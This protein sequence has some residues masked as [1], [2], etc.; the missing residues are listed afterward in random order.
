MGHASAKCGPLGNSIALQLTA[1]ICKRFRHGIMSLPP[2][3]SPVLCISYVSGG[4]ASQLYSGISA[5]G[6]YAC[7]DTDASSYRAIMS[8]RSTSLRH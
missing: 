8:V 3:I 6:D 7:G 4:Y 5:C 2:T 1:N